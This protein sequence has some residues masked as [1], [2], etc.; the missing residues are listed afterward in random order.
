MN[1]APGMGF[2]IEAV[3]SGSLTKNGVDVV[4]GKTMIGYG[5]SVVWKPT[6]RVNS[7][8]ESGESD[9]IIDAFTIRAA[10]G[11]T[12]S[13]NSVTV[14]VAADPAGELVAVND[15]VLID[16]DAR[17]VIIDVLANDSGNGTLVV[18]GV[19]QPQRGSALLAKGQVSYTPG[20]NFHGSDQFAYSVVDSTQNTGTATV[21]VEVRSVNDPPEAHDDHL[22]VV[23]NSV[24]NT[25]DVLVDAYD[26]DPDPLT[27]LPNSIPE[28][29][30]IAMNADGTFS[31]TPDSGYTGSD[32]FTYLACDGTDQS[33]ATVIITVTEDADSEGR[34]T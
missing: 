16:E 31:Y 20:P 1:D 21:I 8:E 19:G 14:T 17:D 28:S 4:P 26:L 29:G 3:N 33:M 24:N 10:G 6:A 9:G 30:T 12:V 11:A 2:R 13:D 25:I 18:A 34:C 7:A 5:E 32:S 15:T 23:M 27:A 22:I